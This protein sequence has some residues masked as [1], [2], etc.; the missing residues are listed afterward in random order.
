MKPYLLFYGSRYYPCGGWSDFQ[1]EFDTVE[2]AKAAFMCAD[3]ERMEGGE[4]WAQIVCTKTRAV[5]KR[6]DR[7]YIF[8]SETYVVTERNENKP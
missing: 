6:L 4:Q 2:E 7:E 5:V 3:D 8:K 1:G